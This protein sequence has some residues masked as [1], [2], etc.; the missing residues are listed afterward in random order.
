[1]RFYEGTSQLAPDGALAEYGHTGRKLMMSDIK[2]PL[3]Q[4]LGKEPVN[5]SEKQNRDFP[6]NYERGG[7][8]LA[9]ELSRRPGRSSPAQNL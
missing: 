4:S 2:E 1:M 9:G 6:P 3:T 5:R 8:G 7:G